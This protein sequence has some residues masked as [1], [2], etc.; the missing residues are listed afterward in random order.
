VF[1]GLGTGGRVHAGMWR[2]AERRRFRRFESTRRLAG[3][4][5][6]GR[7]QPGAWRLFAPGA[8]QGQT[9]IRGVA[10]S[11]GGCVVGGKSRLGGEREFGGPE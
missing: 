1:I 2:G 9:V 5:G 3:L 7:F 6:E 8:P 4:F 11:V 10:T